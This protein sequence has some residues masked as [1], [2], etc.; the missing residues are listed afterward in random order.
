MTA[1]SS[2]RRPRPTSIKARREAAARTD[3]SAGIP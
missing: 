2:P 1:I 3:G